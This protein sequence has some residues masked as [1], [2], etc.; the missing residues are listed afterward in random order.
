MQ[1]FEHRLTVNGIAVTVFEW[2]P[3]ARGAQDTVLLAHATGF[4]ARCWDRVVAQLGHRHVLALDQRGHGRSDKPAAVHW[5]EFGR[6]LVEVI[7]TFD[8]TGVIGVGHSMGGHAMTD[9]AAAAPERFRRLV[10][11]DP[12]IAAPAAYTLTDPWGALGQGSVHPAA[13]RRSRWNSAEEM[14]TRFA[15]RRPFD[16]WDREVLWDYCRY[17][18][19]PA[20]DGEGFDLACPPVFEAQVYMNSLGN[21]A[22]HDSVRAV[23]VPVTVVRAM[24]PPTT[25]DV[26]DF[27]YSPT[28]PA[29]AAHFRHGR[30]LHL[31][32]HT[33]FLPMENPA[34]A[35]RLALGA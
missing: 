28:W 30:D 2:H 19:L 12:V 24:E 14:V 18:L 23:T 35:A 33:H 31:P 6:D 4:H 27:R 34:L 13:K 8:L 9:A 5:R 21:G 29:L 16:T 22:V 15:D 1:P 20:G 3:T 32:A 10:L 11:I 25:R 26:L 7:Q 17:G